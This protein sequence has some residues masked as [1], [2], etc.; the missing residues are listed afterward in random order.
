V[1]V[2]SGRSSHLTSTFTEAGDG[3]ACDWGVVEEVGAAVA[4][5]PADGELDCVAVA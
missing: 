3:V 4:E 5:A 2:C 1:K